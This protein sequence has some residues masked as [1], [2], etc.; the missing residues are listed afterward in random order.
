MDEH[1]PDYHVPR[2]CRCWMLWQ[3]DVR[4]DATICTDFKPNEF[5]TL[6]GFP[7]CV[8]C[9]HLDVCH[10]KLAPAS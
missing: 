6:S 3:G 1:E 8:T 10:R 5:A 2:D 9:K 4:A 7:M